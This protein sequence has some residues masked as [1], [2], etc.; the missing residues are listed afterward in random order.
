MYK[1]QNYSGFATGKRLNL[2]YNTQVNEPH[3]NQRNHT[4]PD[5]PIE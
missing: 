3:A 4:T 1:L 5:Y 2:I